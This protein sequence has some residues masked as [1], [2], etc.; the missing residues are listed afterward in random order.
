MEVSVAEKRK[1]RE[2]ALA[3]VSDVS[4]SS[5]SALPGTA[6]FAGDRLQIRNE[7]NNIVLS[8]HLTDTEVRFIFF[9]GISLDSLFFSCVHLVMKSPAN[10]VLS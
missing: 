9:F 2:F 7:S 6:V 8:A 4:S 10:V 3:S 5:S 1:Q